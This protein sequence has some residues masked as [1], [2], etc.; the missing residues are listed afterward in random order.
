MIREVKGDILTSG[1]KTI[2]QSIAPADHFDSGLALALREL[3]PSMAKDFR[4]FCHQKS[5]KPGDIWAWG[6]VGGKRII[7]LMT[8][9]PVESKK[10]GGHPGKATLSNMAKCLKNL[11]QL[12][13]S[14][15][16]K[17]MA[18]P[19]LATGVGGLDWNDVKS[20]IEKE[21]SDSEVEIIVYSTYIKGLKA[22]E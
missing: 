17:N 13:K 8:Q 9:E 14:E 19:K 4:H 12:A 7:N 3:H 10:G 2:V 5:P 16:I 22:E 20:L 1:C 18:M 21:F 11:H 6:G 15:N